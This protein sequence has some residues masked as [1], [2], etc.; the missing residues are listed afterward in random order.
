MIPQPDTEYQPLIFSTESIPCPECN[1]LTIITPDYQIVCPNCGLVVSQVYAYT[2][3]LTKYYDEF[4]SKQSVY[5]LRVR[6]KHNHYKLLRKYSQILELPNSVFTTAF[7]LLRR[8]ESKYSNLMRRLGFRNWR[9]TKKTILLVL[10]VSMIIHGMK[11]KHVKKLILKK[12]DVRIEYCNVCEIIKQLGVDINQYYQIRTKL[13]LFNILKKYN[14]SD[15]VSLMDEIV[16]YIKHNTRISSSIQ[17]LLSS[18]AYI[19]S[20][21]YNTNLTLDEIAKEVGI[22]PNALRLAYRKIL[23]TIDLEVYV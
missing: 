22:T 16:N 1:T 21:L 12:L 19:I 15:R 8:L 23:N 6:V 4:H 9:F 5:P 7:Y 17:T 13:L 14:L 11:Y 2:P 10:A 3:P 20:K 18:T